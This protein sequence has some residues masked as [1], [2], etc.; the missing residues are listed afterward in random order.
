[1]DER[2]KQLL[3]YA[4]EIREYCREHATCDD[5]PFLPN[6]EVFKPCVLD[7]GLPIGWELDMVLEKEVSD[8]E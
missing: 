2:A 6:H 7:N 1:M 4:A 3:R 5:C 8:N